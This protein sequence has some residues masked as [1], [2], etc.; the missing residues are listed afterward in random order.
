MQNMITVYELKIIIKLISNAKYA[1]IIL[2]Q[3]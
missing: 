3:M 2:V 1:K